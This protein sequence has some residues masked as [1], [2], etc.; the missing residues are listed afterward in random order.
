MARQQP[1]F[2]RGVVSW[3]NV[4]RR[5]CRDDEE[6]LRDRYPEHDDYSATNMHSLRGLALGQAA[7]LE[8][9]LGEII[10]TLDPSA[11]LDKQTAGQRLRWVEKLVDID[12]WAWELEA[13]E[14]A[15]KTR[16]RLAHNEIQIG[17]VWRDYATGDGGEFVP[18]I[19]LLG[20]VDYDE[21]DLLS[22]L[23]LMQ[24]ATLMAIEILRSQLG[25]T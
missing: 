10:R 1:P 20:Q 8:S 16:N 5:A 25:G 19:S 15:V 18:V 13:I 3:T 11:K 24:H 22:D 6:K 12:D 7:E 17:S 14:K 9:A 21:S 23:S 4:W 2:G